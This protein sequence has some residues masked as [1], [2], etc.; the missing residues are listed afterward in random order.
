[1]LQ[2]LLHCAPC[3]DYHLSL[4]TPFT[5]SNAL[6][7]STCHPCPLPRLFKSLW[8][9]WEKINF[10]FP[11]SYKNSKSW[12]VACGQVACAKRP[13]GLA[14]VAA[15]LVVVF[16]SFLDQTTKVLQSRCGLLRQLGH[17][18]LDPSLRGGKGRTSH[19][20]FERLLTTTV[21]LSVEVGT[22]WPMQG[23]CIFHHSYGEFGTSP[24]APSP[25]TPPL[26]S[27]SGCAPANSQS[28][29]ARS[30]AASSHGGCH[31]PS[32]WACTSCWARPKRQGAPE[33]VQ[34]PVLTFPNQKYSQKS[35]KCC[36]VVC[37]WCSWCLCPLLRHVCLTGCWAPPVFRDQG[38]AC[39]LYV[40][41]CL[42]ELAWMFPGSLLPCHIKRQVTWCARSVLS[43][44]FYS[45]LKGPVEKQRTCWRHVV[46]LTA[47][48][49]DSSIFTNL[50]SSLSSRLSLRVAWIGSSRRRCGSPAPPPWRG[51][52]PGAAGPDLAPEPE[53]AGGGVN[54]PTDRRSETEEKHSEKR[55]KGK[56]DRKLIDVDN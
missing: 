25:W 38:S 35:Q 28:H 55:W 49:Q 50:S 14:K 53:N 4:L 8:E 1:M 18:T 56:V 45:R 12:K 36:H 13:R 34:L 23:P 51:A 2:F 20:W 42:L 47:V 17:P 29:R 41:V 27:K 31:S 22:L 9:N 43:L 39:C 16:D 10:Q 37:L 52:P 46:S 32:P 48:A 24:R 21:H 33:V 40:S 26:C 11:S 3:N 19:R 15:Q 6:V 7:F 30:G 44:L 5:S 54:T